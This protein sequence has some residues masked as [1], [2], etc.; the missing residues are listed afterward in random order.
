MVIDSKRKYYVKYTF[1]V[2]WKS[3]GRQNLISQELDL[4]GF[5]AN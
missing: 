4:F 3:D 1:E 2:G 5:N